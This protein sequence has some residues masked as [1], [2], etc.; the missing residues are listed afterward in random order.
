MVSKVF[1]VLGLLLIIIGAV[2]FLLYK[3]NINIKIP[4][5]SLPGD[6]KIQK[7]NFSFYMPIAS[8]I[9]ISIVLSVLLWLFTKFIK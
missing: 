8:S 7:G 6:I 5:G 3:F 9:I 2:L 4:F 1:I